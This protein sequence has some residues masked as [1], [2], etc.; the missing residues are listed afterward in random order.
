MQNLQALDVLD[1]L[2]SKIPA[3]IEKMALP[4]YDGKGLSFNP[5]LQHLHLHGAVHT[6]DNEGLAC[7]LTLCILEK[8]ICNFTNSVQISFIQTLKLFFH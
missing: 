2:T 3:H 1:I 5:G 4:H 6:P 8:I 7:R